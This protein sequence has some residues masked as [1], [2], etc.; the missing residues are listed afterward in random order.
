MLFQTAGFFFYHA[1][2][3]AIDKARPW[4][5]C[6][7]I[8]AMCGRFATEEEAKVAIEALQADRD[9][10]VLPCNLSHWD[11]RHLLD[12]KLWPKQEGE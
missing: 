8:G 5:L 3:L 12:G 9:A 2:A 10:G 4:Q 11:K 1:G 6:S 7:S